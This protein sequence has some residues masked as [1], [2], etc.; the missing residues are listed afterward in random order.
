[1]QPAHHSYDG[2]LAKKAGA[3]RQGD[4]HVATA[5]V[6]NAGRQRGPKFGH[7]TLVLVRNDRVDLFTE[8][9]HCGAPRVILLH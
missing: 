4:A 3:R 5:R 8:L 1:M 9:L 2:A 6:E 7:D